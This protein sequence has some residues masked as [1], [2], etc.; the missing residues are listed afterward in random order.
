MHDDKETINFRMYGRQ[1]AVR[2]T[3][4]G[5]RPALF[6]Q[7]KAKNRRPY[8]REIRPDSKRGYCLYREVIQDRTIEDFRHLAGEELE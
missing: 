3:D 4:D 1:F 8:W 7:V 5:G 2:F 6:E